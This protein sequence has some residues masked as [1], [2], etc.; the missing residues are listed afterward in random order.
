MFKKSQKVNELYCFCDYRLIRHMFPPSICNCLVQ[1]IVML[2]CRRYI[3]SSVSYKQELQIFE[4]K[5]ASNIFWLKMHILHMRKLKPTLLETRSQI[6]GFGNHILLGKLVL[7][8]ICSIGLW[9]LG[10]HR[11]FLQ[12]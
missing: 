4:M 3:Y 1:Y 7:Y 12:K 2:P 8:G 5:G 11:T 9:Y 6:S 10:G